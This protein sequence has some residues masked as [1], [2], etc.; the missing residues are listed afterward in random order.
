MPKPAIVYKQ[1]SGVPPEFRYIIGPKFSQRLDCNTTAEQLSC[2]E[3][4]YFSATRMS[5]MTNGKK[6]KA[7]PVYGFNVVPSVSKLVKLSVAFVE[8]TQ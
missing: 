6:C 8:A 4:R 1:L 2:D 5:R 3:T 7:K